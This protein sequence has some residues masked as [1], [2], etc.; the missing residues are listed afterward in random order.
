MSGL[1]SELRSVGLGL[2]SR[3]DAWVRRARRTM[4]GPA[5]VRLV[6]GM[7]ALAGLVVA[8]PTALSF[9]S[10]FAA[11]LPMAAGV[12]LFPRTRW[13]SVVA[14]VTVGAWLV[15][16]IAFEADPIQPGRIAALAG[17]L[18]VTHSASAL[19]AVLPYDS[20]VSAGLMTRWAV[21]TGLALAAGVGLGL[22]GMVVLGQFRSVRSIVGPIA[23]SLV[24]A[25]LV[26]LL[27]WHLR[28]RP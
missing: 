14:L 19:A 23:G 24:V 8:V 21:R 18:Y 20:V 13:V 17:A 16:T 22:A 3:L 2:H 28:R 5:L 6:A 27:A 4:P 10:L 1:E 15:N 9:S 11:G 25:G 12:S 26:G 7:A